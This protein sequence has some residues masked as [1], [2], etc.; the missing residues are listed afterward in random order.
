MTLNDQLKISKMAFNVS[1]ITSLFLI[2]VINHLFD[3]VVPIPRSEFHVS[4]KSESVVENAPV[5]PC[6]PMGIVF[7]RSLRVKMGWF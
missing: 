7:G 6:S 3:I 4:T 2:M 5:S 1:G